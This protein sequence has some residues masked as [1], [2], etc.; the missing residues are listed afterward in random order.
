MRD[1]PSSPKCG[2]W[3]PSRRSKANP[4]SAR[5]KNPNRN[6][7]EL[8]NIDL[9]YWKTILIG[10][11]GRSLPIATPIRA[12]AVYV[13]D[14]VLNVSSV[15]KIVDC[16]STRFQKIVIH[17]NKSTRRELVIKCFQGL[18]RRFVHV[19][20]ETKKR[21]SLNGG[22]RYRILEPS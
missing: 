17:Y 11:G 5:G 14:R 1:A 9:D 16:L 18:N 12:H 15:S 20:V 21:Q 6:I 2:A 22:S 4:A 10:D 13:H 19:P 3:P 7:C 8:N